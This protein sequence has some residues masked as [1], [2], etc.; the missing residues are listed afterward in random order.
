M[1]IFYRNKHHTDKIHQIQANKMKTLLTKLQ[2]PNTEYKAIWNNSNWMHDISVAPWL[3]QLLPL[4]SSTK[5][6]TARLGTSSNVKVSSTMLTD[7]QRMSALFSWIH[8]GRK[9]QQ[10]SASFW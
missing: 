2:Y 5:V 3:Q 1:Q 6:T 7:K 4:L 8:T 9:K 10:M